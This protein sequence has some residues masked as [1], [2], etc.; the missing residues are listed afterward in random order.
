MCVRPGIRGTSPAPN[1]ILVSIVHSAALQGA[2]GPSKSHTYSTFRLH[3][4]HS[5]LPVSESPRSSC[6]IRPTH[7]EHFAFLSYN[8]TPTHTKPTTELIGHERACCFR[9]TVFFVSTVAFTFQNR[10]PLSF[11][12]TVNASPFTPLED[13]WSVIRTS[14][15]AF[16]CQAR[17]REEADVEREWCRSP[18]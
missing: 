6:T 12:V 9:K 5:E 17:V 4:V 18:P 3:I 11:N 2:L 15:E 8:G 16:F 14:A 7:T 10:I 1:S 13:E